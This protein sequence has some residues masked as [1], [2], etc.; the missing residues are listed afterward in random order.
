ML[1]R[2]DSMELFVAVAKASSF[3]RAA[4]SLGMPNSTLSRRVTMLEE[5]LGFRLF[6]RTTRTVCLTEIGQLYFDRCRSLVDQAHYVA[7]ELKSFGKSVSGTIR[8]NL[9]ADHGSEFLARSFSQFSK[10]YPEVTFALDLGLQ[11]VASPDGP[12]DVAIRFGEQPN[13][14]KIARLVGKMP[15]GVYASQAYLFNRKV[16]LVPSDLETL[17]VVECSLLTCPGESWRLR[18]D[19]ERISVMP[20]KRHSSNSVAMTARLAMLG[21][22]LAILPEHI[23]ED[24]GKS[25]ELIRVLPKWSG[26]P[27]SIYALTDTRLLPVKTRTFIEFLSED[28]LGDLK[29]S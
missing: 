17:D 25:E 13:S 2:L 18:C 6:N 16:P 23:G 1:R 10:R 15:T 27:I 29:G 28:L 19:A 24:K 20:R 12:Y 3:T 9:P 7:D 4:A 21:E 5:Q 8:V 11:D 22:G 26:E 14:S